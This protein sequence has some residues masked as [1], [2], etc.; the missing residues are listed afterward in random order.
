MARLAQDAPSVYF[1]EPYPGEALYSIIARLR[2]H[3]GMTHVT[4]SW[5]VFGE[6]MQVFAI[7]LPFR[8]EAVMRLIPPRKGLDSEAIVTRHT[9]FPYC[10]SI[11]SVLGHAAATASKQKFPSH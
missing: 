9:G 5:T 3:V 4:L 6:E 11:L 7:N 2:Q 8:I 10:V 1:P